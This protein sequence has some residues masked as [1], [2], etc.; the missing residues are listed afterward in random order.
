MTD[1]MEYVRNRR[2]ERKYDSTAV[3]R[4]KLDLILEAGL[5]SPTGN[6]FAETEFIVVEDKDVLEYLS[7]LRRFATRMLDTAGAAIIVIADE[8]KSNLWIEDASIAMAYMHLAASA[9][10]LGSCWVQMRTRTDVNGDDLEDVLRE[11]FSIPD[12]MGV[13]AILAVGNMGDKKQKPARG[14]PNW[15]RVHFGEF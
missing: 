9:M 3:S 4:D 11:K 10:G 13:L 14:D 12:N 5:R 1:I 15:D 2:S 8:E 6:N 7:S